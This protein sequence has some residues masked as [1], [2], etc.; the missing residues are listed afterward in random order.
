M[1]GPFTNVPGGI[2]LMGSERGQD[3]ERP[4]HEVYVDGF[5]MAVFPVTRGEYARFVEATGHA[6]ARDWDAP[7]PMAADVPVVGVSWHD[8][9]AYCEWLTHSGEAVRL[10]TEAEWER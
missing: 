6:R 7:A 10:P 8:A 5:A 2:F 3:D 9:V 1:D 4:V